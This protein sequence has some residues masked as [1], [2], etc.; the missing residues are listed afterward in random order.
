MSYKPEID[1]LRAIAVLSVLLFHLGVPVVDGGFSGVDIFFVIS[2]Y[3]ITSILMRDLNEG[4]FSIATFYR[5]R[6]LRILPALSLVLVVTLILGREVLLPS[7][8][9]TLGQSII[10]ALLFASNIFFWSEL[11]YF[12][13]DAKENP[14]L[15]TWSLGVEEQFYILVPILLWLLFRYARRWLVPLFAL[16]VVISF[17]LAAYAVE[18]MPRASFY[19]L[20]TRY[21]ELGV[22][23]LLAMLSTR[24]TATGLLAHGL[25]ALGLALVGAG[26]FWLTS[27]SIFP[28]PWASLPVF[29]AAALI[30]AGGQSF[31]GRL[32][33][34]AGPVWIG[35]ISYS[36]Y[37]WHWPL[38]VLWKLRTDPTLSALE[39]LCIGLLSIVLA[40]LSTRFVEQPFRHLPKTLTNARVLWPSLAVL[41]LGSGI[42]WGLSQMPQALRSYPAQVVALDGYAD[43]F[44]QPEFRSRWQY[45]RCHLDPRSGGFRAFDA[46]NCLTQDARPT[47]LVFG[48]SH[49]AH[50]W[51][52]LAEARPDLNVIQASSTNCR[53]LP[54]H[55]PNTFCGRLSRFI[56]DD[57]L[58]T[59]QPEMVILS[60]VWR[61]KEL[62]ALS[63]GIHTIQAAGVPQVVVLG[64]TVTYEA[65]LPKILARRAL[66][67]DN[68]QQKLQAHLRAGQWARNSHL[69]E[70]VETAN[71]KYIDLLAMIC[72]KG[73]Q[74][75]QAWVDEVPLLFDSNHY[76][77]E[78][79]EKL[80]ANIAAGL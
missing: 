15:H 9:A 20:P 10:A 47:V 76:T 34:L 8:M 6:A 11:D 41:V 31:T 57:W 7:E 78:A 30:A 62:P 56:Y 12:T 79:A 38:I 16:S 51:R 1:G 77:A 44:D 2:G 23:S 37:L 42:G 50:I 69:R 39:M 67:E 80:G 17:G 52:G 21:W 54:T 22:G 48:D 49:A 75:C 70:V 29:G 64:D 28:G 3:L 24:F 61:D 59:H 53:P 46:E 72:P 4:S 73:P 33:S 74:S 55:A 71:A 25:G 32:L 13:P 19:L 58:P 65:K 40:A 27:D 5:R 14:L 18:P 68:E 36:L 43:Y 26:I 63:E 45:H 66:F 60:G 35:K